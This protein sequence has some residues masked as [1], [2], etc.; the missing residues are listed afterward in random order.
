MTTMEATSVRDDYSTGLEW[1]K[2]N[3]S[4]LVMWI[5]LVTGVILFLFQSSIAFSFVA[6]PFPPPS[7]G[8]SWNPDELKEAT[9]AVRTAGVMAFSAGL[10]ERLVITIN[11]AVNK[12]KS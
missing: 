4:L 10:V 12:L 2:Q 9:S 8:F 1:C 7:Q 3:R 6:K 11:A 5:L